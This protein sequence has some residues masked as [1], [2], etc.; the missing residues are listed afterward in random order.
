MNNLACMNRSLSALL[1]LLPSVVMV[2]CASER[3][4]I[5]FG[6][7][8]AQNLDDKLRSGQY[9]KKFDNVIFILDTSATMNKKYLYEAFD[10]NVV[11]TML[12]VEKEIAHRLNQTLPNMD[13]NAGI[14]TFGFG[15]CQS[16]GFSAER[17]VVGPH[18]RQTFDEALDTIECA[19]GGSPL[20][21]AI[22][23]AGEDL[24]SL[25]GRT[26]L[27]IISDG[28]MGDGPFGE[29]VDLRREYDKQ[30]CVYTISMA[31]N[32]QNKKAIRRLAAYSGCGFSILAEDLA[33]PE[34]MGKYVE[35]VFLTKP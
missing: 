1:C 15:A 32:Y 26:A 9:K 20:D 3:M 29:V 21:Y 6:P 8:V 23:Q 16:W 35:R 34:G 25:N 24:A 10:T 17:L 19:G 2:G 22:E 7:F 27:I 33:D 12:E 4:P 14:R 18:A 31:K 28:D 11:P 13:I 5:T 30:V